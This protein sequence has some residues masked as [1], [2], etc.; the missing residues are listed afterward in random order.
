VL[1][2][3]RVW[4]LVTCALFHGSLFHLLVN[5]LGIWIFGRLVEERIGA[6]RYLLFALGT[7]LSASLAFLLLAALRDERLPMIGASGFDFGVMVLCAFWYPR[8][9]LLLFFV[10]PV[11]LWAAALLFVVIEATLLLERGGGIAHSAHLGGAL[12]GFLYYRYGGGIERIL[13]GF[14]TWQARRR[15][16]EADESRRDEEELRRQVDRILDKVNREGMAA[17]SDGERRFLKEASQRLRR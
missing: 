4:Q 16:R 11:P 13:G 10:L 12:Y 8:L 9:T 17:L 15:Q 5:C 1:E 14:E 7:V 6:R 2:G 3:L